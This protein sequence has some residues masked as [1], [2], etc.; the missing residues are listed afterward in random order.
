MKRKIT[1]GKQYKHFKGKIVEVIALAKDSE[2]LH[3]VNKNNALGIFDS[4]TSKALTIS[5]MDEKKGKI[6][7][8]ADF[9]FSET[10]G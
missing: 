3:D 5:A 8:R 2:D 6:F 10:S 1:V 9:C 4:K 7:L